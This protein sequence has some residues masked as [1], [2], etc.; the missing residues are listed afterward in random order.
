M[1]IFLRILLTLDQDPRKRPQNPQIWG[2]PG[3]IGPIYY[4][5]YGILRNITVSNISL[6]LSN[7]AVGTSAA[8]V[9]FKDGLNRTY[10]V[11]RERLGALLVLPFEL[12]KIDWVGY[13]HLKKELCS[14]KHLW[15]SSKHTAIRNLLFR[16][17]N[18][19]I[20]CK[21]RK[22]QR[23]Q[24]Y[25]RWWQSI[26]LFG[27]HF[28]APFFLK[29]FFLHFYR[30][31]FTPPTSLTTASNWWHDTPKPETSLGWVNQTSRWTAEGGTQKNIKPGNGG[32]CFCHN[33]CNVFQKIWG[34]WGGNMG[35]NFSLPLHWSSKQT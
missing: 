10:Q 29:C 2:N 31:C 25:R 9:F 3:K 5:Y 7:G 20:Y 30:F 13:Y 16:P 22:R 11:L 32:Y 18:F 19:G 27:L 28:I 8:S 21:Y 26:P 12:H 23:Y 15:C 14:R 4:G 35:R 1:E 34:K 24:S 17:W 33:I 6:P